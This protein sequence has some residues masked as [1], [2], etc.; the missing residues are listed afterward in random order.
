MFFVCTN[1]SGMKMQTGLRVK[2]FGIIFA[3]IFENVQSS[4]LR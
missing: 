2:R 3:F 1:P 4:I